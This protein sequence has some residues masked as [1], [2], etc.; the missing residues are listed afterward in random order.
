MPLREGFS[1]RPEE[2]SQRALASSEIARSATLDSQVTIADPMPGFVLPADEARGGPLHTLAAALYATT[3]MEPGAVAEQMNQLGIRSL[4]F[5]CLVLGF[6]GGILVYQAGIQALRIVPDTSTIGPAYIE[7]LVRDLAASLT[8][9]MLATRVGAG[10]AAEIG[11][12]KV[13]DQLDALR[14]SS[15]DPVVHL[16][17][18]RLVASVLVTPLLTILGGAVA[19]LTGTL[20]GL[21]VFDISLHTFLDARYVDAADLC[22]GLL[23]SVAFGLA[24]PVMSAHAGLYTSGGSQGVG[25]ATTRAVV[26][27]SLAVIVLGFVIGALVEVLAGGAG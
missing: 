27:S 20:T 6:V 26:G 7:I 8:A 11:S 19:L 25:N 3:R 2:R 14:L 24:I 16:V 23:K 15:A 1:E 4:G 9:L 17:A 10:I 5:V 21:W 18:P 22:A 13:T 12:M